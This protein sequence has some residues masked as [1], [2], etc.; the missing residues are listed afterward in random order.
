M[1]FPENI[2]QEDK[3]K[4]EATRVREEFER[5]VKEEDERI[6]AIGEEENEMLLKELIKN[7]ALFW[8]ETSNKYIYLKLGSLEL[9]GKLYLYQLPLPKRYSHL[10][11]V[12]GHC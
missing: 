7:G 9:I 4:N 8:M 11:V 1:S 10:K 5:I 3:L 2:A 6:K 12:V